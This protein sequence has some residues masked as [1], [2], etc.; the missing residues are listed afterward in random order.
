MNCVQN[1]IEFLKK[2]K[3]MYFFKIFYFSSLFAKLLYCSLK[4][5]VQG[6]QNT[7]VENLTENIG[8]YY[9]TLVNE[10]RD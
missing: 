10:S 5:I 7:S 4:I 2:K 6:P 8:I 9:E 3:K 1:K